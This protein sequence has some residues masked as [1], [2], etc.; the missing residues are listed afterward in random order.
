MKSLI[1]KEDGDVG[2]MVGKT[3]PSTVL[4]PIIQIEPLITHSTRTRHIILVKIFDRL[5]VRFSHY[6]FYFLLLWV[7]VETPQQLLLVVTYEIA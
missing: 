2:K 6:L 5:S 3:D 7:S 4:F 1:V